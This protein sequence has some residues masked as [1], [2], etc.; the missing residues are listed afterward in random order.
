[1]TETDTPA[2][3]QAQAITPPTLLELFLAFCKMSLSGFGGVLPWARRQMIEE[4]RWLTVAEFNELFSL[5]Q[6][7]PGANV[8]NMS[9]VFGS[10][11]GGPVGAALA[12]LGL[13]G[14]PVLIVVVLAYFYAQYGD[15]DLLRRA[16]SG[17]AASAAGLIIATT[18]KMAGPLFSKPY[19]T[20]PLI[21]ALAFVAVAIF[22]LPLPYVLLT[23]VP[24]SI[25]LAY[26]RL[27]A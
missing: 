11:F 13:M 26:L 12:L 18:M 9:V 14:P 25:G 24:L 20:A 23:L 15:L 17:I 4:R 8:V 21:V 22:R 27:R 10:R 2:P 19:T 5:A 1:M 6:F 16:L 3:R 7:L